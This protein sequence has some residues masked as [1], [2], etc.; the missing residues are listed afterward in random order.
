MGQVSNKG[1][2]TYFPVAFL[3][4]TPLP[5]LIALLFAGISMLRKRCSWAEWP[6]LLIPLVYFNLSLRNVLNIGYRHLLPI[7]P[8]LWTWSG[9]LGSVLANGHRGTR[10]R[11]ASAG[12]A[13]LALWWSQAIVRHTP[14]RAFASYPNAIAIGLSLL[15]VAL[16][17][18]GARQPRRGDLWASLFVAFGLVGTGAWLNFSFILPGET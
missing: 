10:T 16:V 6:L 7:L 14:V 11:W 5:A 4:K 8:F 18:R 3:I 15:V 17:V 2:W 12:A 13:T 1:W 9:R